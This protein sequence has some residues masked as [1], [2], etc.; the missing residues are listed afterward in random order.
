MGSSASA[1]LLGCLAFWATTLILGVFCTGYGAWRYGLWF[2]YPTLCKGLLDSPKHADS[3][4]KTVSMCQVPVVIS[5]TDS[6]L[7]SD[8]EGH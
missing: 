8:I 5:N 7:G 4:L 6:H 3:Q 2:S 1:H